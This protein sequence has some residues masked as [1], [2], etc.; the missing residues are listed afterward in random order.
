MPKKNEAFASP[1]VPEEEQPYPIPE[2][3][4]WTRLKALVETSK[5]KTDIFLDDNMRYVGLEHIEKD[6]GI[7]GYSSATEVKSLKAVFHVGQILYG[8]LRPYLNKHDVAGFDGVCSTDILVFNARNCAKNRYINYF[9]DQRNFI[10]YAV[11][12]SKG[13]NLPRVSESVILEAVCPLP[14][15]SEQH[16]I[17]SRIESLFAKLDEAK[18]KAQAVVDGFELRKSAILHKAFIGELTERWRKEHGVGMDSWTDTT[19]GEQ[20]ELITKGASPRWQ[21]V[22]Y[23][24]DKSQTLFVTSENVREGYLDFTKEK[25]LS[26]EINDIQKR[27]VL[28]YGDVLVNIVGASIGRAA[29]YNLH[30][31]ANTNQAVCIVRLKP[32]ISN[33]FVCAYL[34]APLAQSYYYDNKVETAR[35]NVSLG[36]ISAMRIS[37]PTSSEQKEIVDSLD[38]ILGMQQQAKSAAEAVLIQIDTMK[39]AILARA[40]RGELGTNDPNEESSAKLVF[41]I[42]SRRDTWGKS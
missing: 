15:L 39:K 42:E 37:L 10:E 21:G 7:I 23:T 19:I 4:C 18:E 33:E 1:F 24:D 11:S 9:L 8:K 32:G 2:N 26:N 41:Y 30:Q 6:G 38:K 27:S 34:N 17:V 13:I 14:P 22:E 40:F 28:N 25:Y 16:R 3:W 29:I 5:E 36:S 12:N 31:L 35:A 20:A